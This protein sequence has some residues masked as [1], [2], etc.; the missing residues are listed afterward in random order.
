MNKNL[1]KAKIKIVP[2]KVSNTNILKK[3]FKLGGV[4][5]DLRLLILRTFFNIMY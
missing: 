4:Q 1:P 5:I 3:I 2:G